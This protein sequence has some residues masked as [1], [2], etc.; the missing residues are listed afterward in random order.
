MSDEVASVGPICSNLGIVKQL[1]I[2]VF[3]VATVLAR[4]DQP[5]AK[6]VVGK[7]RFTVIAPECVRIEYAKDGRFVDAKSMFAVGRDAVWRDFKLSRDGSNVTIGTGK[8][9]LQYRPDDDPLNRRKFAAHI[10]RGAEWVDWW[11]GQRNHQNLGGTIRTLDQVKGP[12]DLGE[13]VLARDGWYLLD[14]SSTAL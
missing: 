14:D 6:V 3:L 8:I 2:S 5:E 11:P 12:V 10:A 4:A 9:R 1:L 13:G 7:A